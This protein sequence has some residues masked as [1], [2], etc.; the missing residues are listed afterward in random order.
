MTMTINVSSDN[1]A[2]YTAQNYTKMNFGKQKK[3]ALNTDHICWI[4][5]PF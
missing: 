5:V 1:N 4:N 3:I 2:N